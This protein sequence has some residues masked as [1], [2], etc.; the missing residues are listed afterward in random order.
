MR[1]RFENCEIDSEERLLRMD[2]APVHLSPKAFDLLCA[3]A[4]ARPKAVDKQTLIQ[5]IWPDSFVSD[6]SLAVLAAEVRAVLK[7]S[8][9]TPR[10]LRTVPRF[11]YAFCAEAVDV[12]AQ[13]ATATA[14]WLL[15]ATQRI[16]LRDGATT[17]GRDP[18]C[19]A[20][21]DAESVSRRHARIVLAGS[22]ITVEDLGSKNGTTI[23]GVRVAEPTTVADGDRIAFGS[24]TFLL[25]VGISE[26]VTGA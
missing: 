1:L 14:I 19:D 15:N 11:G 4:A 17:V 13:T 26:T 12:S 8:A 9:D 25:Q 3:L 6:G 22:V 5:K 2:G 18:G 7:D 10:V 23:N 21:I 16:P 24:V 20:T